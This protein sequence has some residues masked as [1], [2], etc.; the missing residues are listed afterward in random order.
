MDEMKKKNSIYS[1]A[2]NPHN[3]AHEFFLCRY[4]EKE[5]EQK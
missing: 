3:D 1:L 5:N 2:L 4:D